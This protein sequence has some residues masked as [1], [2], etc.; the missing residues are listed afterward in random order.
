MTHT[1]SGWTIGR[2]GVPQQA[3]SVI[4]KAATKSK[5]E[6][7]RDELGD[8]VVS[9]AVAAAK[10]PPATGALLEA[11]HIDLPPG[12]VVEEI[13]FEKFFKL[14]LVFGDL[15]EASDKK[16]EQLKKAASPKEKGGKGKAEVNVEIDPFNLP[17]AV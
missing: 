6:A 10:N 17:M 15:R 11:C 12:D 4:A 7:A 13:E 2:P 1:R 3:G 14:G 8:P 5:K 9:D 16:L